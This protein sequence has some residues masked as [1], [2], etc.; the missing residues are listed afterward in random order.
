MEIKKKKWLIKLILIIVVIMAFAVALIF[1]KKYLTTAFLK[2]AIKFFSILFIIFVP[3]IFLGFCILHSN[4]NKFIKNLLALV[5]VIIIYVLS[6][7]TMLSFSTDIITYFQSHNIKS[8]FNNSKEEISVDLSYLEEYKQK[9]YKNGYLDKH[10]VQEILRLS[11]MK[12][13]KMDINYIDEMSDINIKITNKDDEKIADLIDSLEANYY[14]FDYSNDGDVEINIERYKIEESSNKE[15]NEDIVLTGNKDTDIIENIDK[16]YVSDEYSDY[17]FENKIKEDTA[18]GNN[19]FEALKMLLVYDKDLQN[20]I[21]IVNDKNEY[22]L[23]DSYKV[24]S[25]GINITLKEGVEVKKSDF[26]LRLDR[27]ND[28]L[29]VTKSPFYYYEYEPVVTEVGNPENKV[30]LEIKFPRIYTIFELKNIEIIF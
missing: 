3:L 30:T 7:E 1:A 4:K 9:A 12:S 29:E 10:D 19:N 14:L 11:D 22:D 17:L 16:Y 27:Y 24:Y 18:K 21:P 25:T 2:I 23:I 6:I 26:T 8:I 5:L 13:K 28:N 15:K 20:Y